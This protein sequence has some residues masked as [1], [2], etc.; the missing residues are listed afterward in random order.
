M[1]TL[2][3]LKSFF[4]IVISK[5]IYGIVSPGPKSIIYA[6]YHL[7]L[8]ENNFYC[9]IFYSHFFIKKGSA[10]C[11][12]SNRFSII[13]LMV[14]FVLCVLSVFKCS[15]SFTA[16]ISALGLSMSLGLICRIQRD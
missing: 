7:S 2:N 5:I 8:M 12:A 10:Y 15:C 11:L 1:E 3:I 6:D 14:V 16:S 13:L 9:Y 4:I